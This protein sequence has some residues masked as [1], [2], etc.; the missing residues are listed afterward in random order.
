MESDETTWAWPNISSIT[1]V[2]TF[3][4]YSNTGLAMRAMA[5]R[6]CEGVGVGMMK[7]D[8]ERVEGARAFGV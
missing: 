3:S 4:A 6:I 2:R 7:V 8:D 1:S 5:L